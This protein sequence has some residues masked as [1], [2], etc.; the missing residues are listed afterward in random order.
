MEVAI[1]NVRYSSNSCPS[2]YSPIPIPN[3]NPVNDVTMDIWCSTVTQPTL[4]KTRIVTLTACTDS[5]RL[6]NTCSQAKP[7]LTVVVT[8]DDY[9]T[10]DQFVI[11]PTCSTTCGTTMT[12]DSWVFE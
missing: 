3:P 11:T 8:F 7:Y 5:T 12:I 9:S 4:A 1:Q 10:S 6:A 2:T